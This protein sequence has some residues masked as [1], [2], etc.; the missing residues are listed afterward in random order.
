V[1]CVGSLAEVKGHRYLIEAFAEVHK[2]FP[3]SRLLII[4]EGACR[5]ELE[6][7]VTKLALEDTV[8]LPGR[9][10]DTQAWLRRAQVFAFPSLSEGQSLSLLEAMAVGLPVVATRVGGNAEIVK[11]G[12]TGNL[13]E[14][15]APEEMARAIGRLLGDVSLASR[16]GQAGRE[17]VKQEFSLESMLDRYEMLYKAALAR[18]PEGSMGEEKAS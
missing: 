16:I 1:I 18:G 15:A 6:A 17:R 14:P 8:S 5:P 13:V 9:I 4:V 12:E 10:D 3:Q 2:Q 11:D 7:L